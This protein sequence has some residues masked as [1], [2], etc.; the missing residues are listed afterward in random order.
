MAEPLEQY[1]AL[2][3]CCFLLLS[4]CLS[5]PFMNAWLGIRAHSALVADVQSGGCA[6]S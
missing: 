2:G 3:S 6:H 4:S 1:G 5:P